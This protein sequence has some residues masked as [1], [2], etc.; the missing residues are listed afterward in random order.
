MGWTLC[1]VDF[2]RS[3]QPT[4]VAA[5]GNNIAWVCG[6]GAPVLLVYQA[7]RAGSGRARPAPCS[8]NCGASYYLK[9]EYGF[10]P[11]PPAGTTRQPAAQMDI[12]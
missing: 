9:P 4:T 2:R 12:V 5:D 1:G 11:E 7:G 8:G 10:Q 6:C 3:G